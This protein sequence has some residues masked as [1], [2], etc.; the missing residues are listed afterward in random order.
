MSRPIKLSRLV[1]ALTATAALL[2]AACGSDDGDDG[3]ATTAS[4]TQEESPFG[5]ANAATGDPVTVGFI[6]EGVT[7]TLD[8]ESELLAAQAA[9]DYANEYLAGAGGRPIEL[10]ICETKGTPAGATDCVAELASAGAQVILNGV[11]GQLPAFAPA[12]EAAGIPLL[13]FLGADPSILASQ[14]TFVISNALVNFGAPAWVAREQKDTRAAFIVIDVPGAAGPI[15]ALAGPLFANVGIPVDVVLVPP[16]TADMTPQVQTAISNGAD[17]ISVF[18]DSTFCLAALKATETLGFEGTTT[19]IPQCLN[20]STADQVDLDGVFMGTTRTN[21]PADQEFALFLDVMEAY[22]P[23]AP[24][25]DLAAGGY[26][27]VLS[28]VRAMAN[29]PAGEMTTDTIRTQL[30]QMEPAALPLGLDGQTFQCNGEQIA[31]SKVFCSASALL[32]TLDADG[33]PSGYEPIE[34][35]DILD[36]G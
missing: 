22:A 4:T 23:D 9:V 33:K 32:T 10:Q 31:I 36:L 2:V 11:S 17:H 7:D 8:N 5:E 25:D 28:F 3:A 19:I 12:A 6:G 26:G 34:L 20:E 18:G 13:L 29:H 16:G 21:S 24:A 30:G 35:G 27:A 14:N 15:S 1:L